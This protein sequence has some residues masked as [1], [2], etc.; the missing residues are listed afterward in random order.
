MPGI[1]A[2]FVEQL[3]GAVGLSIPEDALELRSPALTIHTERIAAQVIRK[4][5]RVS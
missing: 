3:S 2:E 4:A 1:A 5:K